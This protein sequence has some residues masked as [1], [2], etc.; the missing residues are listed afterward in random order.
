VLLTKTAD[1]TEQTGTA[2]GSVTASYW[3][4]GG[5]R[6]AIT[7]ASLGSVD[8]AH[9]D[10]GW[11]EVDATNQPGLYRFDVPDAA[12]ATG[13]EWVVVSAKVASCFVYHERLNLETSNSASLATTL[14]SIVSTL[15]TLATSVSGVA[16]AVWAVGTRTLTSGG[17]AA[18]DVWAYA[19]RTL[20]QSAAQVT[21]IV[22]G[23]DITVR[24]GDTW[25]ITLT[26]LGNISSRT[27]LYF[28][29]KASTDSPDTA[30]LLKV[31]EGVGLQILNG[32]SSVTAGDAGITVN[33]AVTG[34]IT[35]T[36]TAAKSATLPEREDYFYDVQMVTSSG[37][38]TLTDGTFEVE[39]DVTRATS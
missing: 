27:K 35:I 16:A 15:S 36:L 28:T 5:T 38:T 2:H 32:S 11:V 22:Q 13:A 31:E 24:R 30:A 21:A 10:G 4:Q 29:V 6:T 8:A 33:S 23:S 39:A 18:A 37:V 20:T 12:F 26:G 7:M 3:R 19:T 9:S 14:A 1:G 17:F 25:S 34:S